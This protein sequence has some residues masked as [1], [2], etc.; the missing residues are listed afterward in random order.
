MLRLLRQARQLTQDELAEKAKISSKSVY[1]IE[2]GESLPRAKTIG[3]IAGVLE[4]RPGSLHEV[5]RSK[6]QWHKTLEALDA[7]TIQLM[8]KVERTI[9]D[10]LPSRDTGAIGALLVDRKLIFDLAELIAEA[11]PHIP[12]QFPALL[13]ERLHLLPAEIALYYGVDKGG[14]MLSGQLGA[15]LTFVDELAYVQMFPKAWEE[16]EHLAEGW[17]QELAS[18]AS[19]SREPNSET[20]T[21]MTRSILRLLAAR[22]MRQDA[23]KV[24]SLARELSLAQSEIDLGITQGKIASP[25]KSSAIGLVSGSSTLAVAFASALR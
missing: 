11:A 13:A 10:Y 15:L 24:R 3:S 9:T 8:D 1:R 25:S 21:L 16:T 22:V 2:R 7:Q 18:L 12:P 6:V 4:V 5:M 23:E 17:G 20:I 19:A 14:I